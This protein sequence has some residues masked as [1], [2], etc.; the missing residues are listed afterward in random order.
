MEDHVVIPIVN[1]EHHHLCVDHQQMFVMHLK[2]VLDQGL[3]VLE[4]KIIFKK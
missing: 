2:H 3:F 4:K 1:F